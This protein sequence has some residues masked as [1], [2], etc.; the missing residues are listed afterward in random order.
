MSNTTKRVKEIRR[1]TRRKFSSEEKIRIVLDGL[2]GESSIAELCR[3]EGINANLFDQDGSIYPYDCLEFNPDLR[4]ID[5]VSD[6]AFLVMDLMAR[7]RTDLAY[8][9]LNTWLEESGDYDGLAVLRFYLVYRCMVR[10]KVASIQTEQLHE[11]AQGEHAIKARQYLELAHTLADSSDH[12]CMVLMHGFSASGK[13]YTS[14]KLITA[15]PAIRVRSD[16]ERKRLHAIPR[17]Q[18]SSSG[19]ETGL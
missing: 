4:W 19:I 11:D 9:F 7:H 18:H 13:T 6:I 10:L 2:R 8:T 17:R 12:P 16:L 3:Q 1:K 14:G 5:Q 15:M